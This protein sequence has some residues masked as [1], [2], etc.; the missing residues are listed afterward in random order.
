MFTKT[1]AMSS[2]VAIS[3]SAVLLLSGCRKQN[4]VKPAPSVPTPTPTRSIDRSQLAPDPQQN[5][6]RQYAPGLL[7]RTVYKADQTGDLN[8]EI[9]DL[10]VGPGKR[11]EAATLPGGAVFEIRSGN[12]A[13]TIAGKRRDVKTGAT[14]S[15]DDG[16]SFQIEN[17]SADEPVSIRLVLIHGR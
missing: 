16:D 8:V 13:V 7:A 17:T 1:K 15:L 12:G 4:I 6:Y 5:S 3:F 9:W 2:I 11:S 10:L 14:L